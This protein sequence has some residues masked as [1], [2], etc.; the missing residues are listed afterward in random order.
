V[1]ALILVVRTKRAMFAV[2]QCT[3]TVGMI[4]D[5]TIFLCKIITTDAFCARKEVEFCSPIYRNHLWMIFAKFILSIRRGRDRCC[6]CSCGCGC[7]GFLVG[8]AAAAAIVIGS[9]V[10]AVPAVTAASILRFCRRRSF[11]SRGICSR[12]RSCSAVSVVRAVE[13]I[14]GASNTAMEVEI[15]FRA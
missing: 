5:L 12:R 8:A 10:T 3:I 15:G 4:I 14:F 11:G 6:S 13:H 7:G 1:V 2:G 9:A